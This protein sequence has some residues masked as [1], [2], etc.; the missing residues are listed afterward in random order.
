M[1]ISHESIYRA[2]YMI[3]RELCTKLRTR[4]PTRKNKK[5]TVKGPWRS[6]IIGARPC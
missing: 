6:R 3:P 1:R 4:R 5:N 2:I